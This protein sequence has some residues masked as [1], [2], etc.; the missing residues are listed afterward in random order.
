MKVQFI[1]RSIIIITLTETM[2]KKLTIMQ[3]LKK[4]K[5]F[6]LGEVNRRLNQHLLL[7]RMLTLLK[8]LHK[9]LLLQQMLLK[10]MLPQTLQLKKLLHLLLLLHQLQHLKLKK[11]SLNKKIQR[12][13][14]KLAQLIKNKRK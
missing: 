12:F 10:I 9:R 3:M 13:N 2:R 8:M 7:K 5:N 6:N 14:P 4:R 1:I 11:Q